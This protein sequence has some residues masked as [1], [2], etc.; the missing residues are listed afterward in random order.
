MFKLNFKAKA[1]SAYKSTKDNYYM[2]GL[3]D[4]V[5]DY[6]N[7][8]LFQRPISLGKDD[9]PDED[10]NGLFAECNGDICY[11][12]CK[13]VKITEGNIVF[14]IRDSIITVDTEEVKM[15]KRFTEYAR[16]IFGDLLSIEQ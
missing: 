3:A 12:E 10:I 8:I 15:T 6:R 1:I 16:K 13:S 5:Y 7:Y 4:D 2:I 9:N 14:E 11:N